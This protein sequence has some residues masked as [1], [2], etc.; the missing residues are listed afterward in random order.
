M[1]S[2]RASLEDTIDFSTCHAPRGPGCKE[3]KQKPSAEPLTNL[4]NTKNRFLLLECVENGGR[5]FLFECV[6]NGGGLA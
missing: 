1:E 3:T 4:I 2:V 5:Y 6:E